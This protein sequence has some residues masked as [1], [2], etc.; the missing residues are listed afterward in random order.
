LW[1]VLQDPINNQFFRLRAA[2]YDFIARLR[3]NKTIGQAWEECLAANPDS[4][5]G[6]E[7]AVKLLAQL[8]MAN[9]LHSDLPPDSAKLFER[10]KKRR[11]REVQSRLLN[12]MFMRIPLFDPDRFLKRCLPVARALISPFGALVWLVVV[13]GYQT[14]SRQFRRAETPE[15][16]RARA[17]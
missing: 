7:D 1:H 9:L 10:Y 5:P 13:G 2:A 6:Q 17:G 14:G 12:V 11:E 3:L 15:R 4:A 16:W 8:Y